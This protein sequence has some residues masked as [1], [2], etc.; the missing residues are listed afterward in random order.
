MAKT[1]YLDHAAA[2]PVAPQ[3]LDAMLPWFGA[4]NPHASHA[5]GTEAAGAIRHACALIAAT[6]GV[7]GASIVLTSGATEANNLALRGAAMA[8]RDRAEGRGRDGVVTVA[9]EHSS[10]L[11][12]ARLLER[13]GFRLTL[14]PVD[15]DGLVD[16]AALAAA[17]DNRTA[18]VSVMAANNETGVIQPLGELAAIAKAA[19]ALF[20]TDASQAYGR[21][22][23]DIRAL[24]IDLLS[25]SGHKIGGPQGVGA[26]YVR[27]S[28]PAA[29]EPLIVGGGQQRGLRAGTVPVPLAVGLGEAARLPVDLA[30]DLGDIREVFL[31]EVRRLM[32]DAI[33]H[34]E[35]APRVG[36]ILSLRL[37]GVS[38]EDLLLDLPE[39]A[40]STGSACGSERREPS[41]VLAA[42]GLS[43]V[44]SAATLRLSFG[45]TTDEASVLEA[46]RRL[47][48][49]A[50][51]QR[52]Q[53]S[54]G[55]PPGDAP[56]A[57]GAILR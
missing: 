56:L 35:R 48:A 43:P 41:H 21:M 54:G 40:A 57:S 8:A 29:L 38:A 49:A 45:R 46:A 10:V 19:G 11:E 28:P 36:H 14:L 17:V 4:A 53:A 37:P 18:I 12:S 23:L 31:A 52:I 50:L 39:I 47:A 20:H 27:P 33:M 30:G 16:P 15:G 25:L 34:G 9:T 42:M 3:V 1:I 24:G 51:A 2:T 44:E 6:F 13:D 32:P 55:T 7:D 26:L 22:P 5:A